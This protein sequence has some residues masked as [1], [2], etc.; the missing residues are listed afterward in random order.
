MSINDIFFLGDVHSRVDVVTETM[1]LAAE[2]GID[3]IIQVGDF[4]CY[5]PDAITE[6]RRQRHN[7]YQRYR[8][9]MTIHFIDGNHED[10][11][12]I[13][14]HGLPQEFGDGT[15]IYHPRGDVSEINGIVVGFFGGAVSVNRDRQIPGTSWFKDEFPTP[16]DVERA[17][18]SFSQGIDLLVTHEIPERAVGQVIHPGINP[19]VYDAHIVREQVD[20][21][22][23][24]SGAPVV[25]HGH[26]HTP[27]TGTYDHG[28]VTVVSMGMEDRRGSVVNITQDREV[29]WVR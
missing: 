3:T 8:I 1:T 6:I 18:Q 11:R 13:N 4:W 16:G 24:S 10:Y 15:M 7:I 14:P 12:I 23:E 20:K 22:L 5:R 2:H 17:R 27:T 9:D 29:T 26:W 19:T 21:V 25:V 28:D